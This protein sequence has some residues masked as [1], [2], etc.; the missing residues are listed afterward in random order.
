MRDRRDETLAEL[1]QYFELSTYEQTDGTVD[2]LV[3]SI[4][5]VMGGTSRGIGLEQETVNDQVE[6]RVRL[7]HDGT[8]MTQPGA[9]IGA[10]LEGR[11]DTLNT[12]IGQLDQV[13][14]QL[15][16]ET[17][18]L[19]ATGT[20]LDG[21]TH[22]TSTLVV[23]GTDRELSL[24]DASNASIADLPFDVKNGGFYI[25]VTNQSTGITNQIRIDID[26]DNITDAGGQGSDDDTSVDDIIAAIN[27][28][29]GVSAGYNA[30]GQFEVSADTGF[31]FAFADDSSN[32]LA[33]LGVN[34][35]FKGTNASSIGVRNDLLEEPSKL[36]TGKLENGEFVENGTA[37]GIAQLGSQTLETLGGESIRSHWLNAVS[38]VAVSADSARVRAEASSI[39]RES[40]QNQRD[41]ISGVNL[42]EEAIDLLTYQRQYQAAHDS[43]LLLIN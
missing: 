30:A 18:K 19:H 10:L 7:K 16:F 31:S 2:V 17:N 14:Q 29:D 9:L 41:A 27:T 11:E 42:D 1:S 8:E 13:T 22:A 28:I 24:A 21:L 43:S 34:S 15:I 36:V 26:L 5:V 12:V 38:G 40:V 32:V 20:N 4:P 37:L 3:D 33:V 25:H 23:S 6:L 39:V 35:F